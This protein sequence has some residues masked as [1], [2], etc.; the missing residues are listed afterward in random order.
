[1]NQLCFITTCMGRLAHLQQSLPRLAGQPGTTCVVVDYSCPEGCGDWVAATHPGVRV[2][3]VPERARFSVCEARNLGAAGVTA[4]WLGF[5]DADVVLDAAFSRVVLPQLRP[6][7]YYRAVPPIAELGGTMV[8]PR[9]DFERV[10]GYDEVIRDWGREDLDLYDRFDLCGLAR[11]AITA[12]LMT[13]LRHDDGLRVQHH[14]V[15]RKE[16]SEGA[17]HLYSRIKLDL[18]RLSQVHPSR[19]VRQRVYDQVRDLMRAAQG[20][21]AA[22]H[23]EVDYARL[24]LATGWKAT[25]QVRIVLEERPAAE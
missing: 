4:P 11:G 1:M 12:N 19:E 24:H 18:M 16:F 5:I 9:A 23:L 14:V 13:P 3:R 6:R 17:N 8:C 21:P 25:A 22:L 20:T 15:K 2:V 10:G 7:T